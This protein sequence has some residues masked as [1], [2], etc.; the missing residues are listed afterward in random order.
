MIYSYTRVS[1]NKQDYL[2]Q[3]EAIKKW[4]TDNNVEIDVSF[5]DTITGKTFN[6]DGYNRMKQAAVSGDTIIIKEL[7]RLGRDW[8]GI[9]EEWKYF[10]DKDINIV[11]IDMP[12][13]SQ[14]IYD[15]DGNIDL[16]IKFLKAIVFETLC[17]NAEL[18][19]QKNSR[20]TSEKL[21][22]MKAEGIKLGRPINTEVDKTVCEL[23]AQG[24]N[25]SDIAFYAGVSRPQVYA[26]LK[27]NHLM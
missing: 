19:R 2:R 11:V 15:K 17:Y 20:R 9:K 6:R 18:E 24:M 7:D 16:N 22:A 10:D 26:I 21:Q 13:L 4:C 1:T 3:D 12:L 8:D 23:Y 5:S 25:K 27:R 14:A